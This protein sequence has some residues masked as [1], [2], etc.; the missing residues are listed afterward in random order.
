M[1]VV[2]TTHF[3]DEAERLADTVVVLDEGR[4][5]AAGSP[6]ELTSAGSEGQIRFSARPGLPLASLIAA[7]PEGTAASRSSSRA[8]TGS[9]AR[10]T[11][12]CWP[13]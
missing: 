7:L 13:S 3:L 4:V 10:S 12:S 11:R 2:L 5:V 8:A 6:A 9:P 1:S